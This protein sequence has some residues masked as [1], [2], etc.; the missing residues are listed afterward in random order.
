MFSFA[1]ACTIFSFEL[2]YI[3]IHAIT[4]INSHTQTFTHTY[5]VFSLH[6]HYTS[7]LSQINIHSHCTPY[8]CSQ[9]LHCTPTNTLPM[10][11]AWPESHCTLVSAFCYILYP[12]HSFHLQHASSPCPSHVPIFQLILPV[13]Q[14]FF[15]YFKCPEYYLIIQHVP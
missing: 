11:S 9:Q 12:I 7:T 15:K 4:L 8:L 1:N 14:K 10:P 3:Y 5:T 2:A 13:E 6:L